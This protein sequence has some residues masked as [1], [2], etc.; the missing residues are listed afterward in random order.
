MVVAALFVLGLL[1]RAI[2]GSD[3]TKVKRRLAGEIHTPYTV[4]RITFVRTKEGD[5][6]PVKEYRARVRERVSMA[7][8]APETVGEYTVYVHRGGQV[9]GQGPFPCP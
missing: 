3:E 9:F 5:A 8:N 6:G 2:E 1:I 4:E 7:P